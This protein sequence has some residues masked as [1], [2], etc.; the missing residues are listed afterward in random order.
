MPC[1]T[2]VVGDVDF[3]SCCLYTSEGAPCWGQTPQEAVMKSCSLPFHSFC[4]LFVFVCA[5]YAPGYLP[6]QLGET[7][8][9][10]GHRIAVP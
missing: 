5:M 9:P 1:G 8:L 10:A 4:P 7:C 2:R 6:W 3:A